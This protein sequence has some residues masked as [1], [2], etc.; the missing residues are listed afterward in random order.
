MRVFAVG[1]DALDVTVERLHDADPRHIVGPPFSKPASM[2]GWSLAIR[3]NC[4]LAWGV[5]R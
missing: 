2:L 4:A 1:E 5:W 3:A